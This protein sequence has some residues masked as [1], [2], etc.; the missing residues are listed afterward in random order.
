MSVPDELLKAYYAQI[1]PCDDIASWLSHGD[2]SL[3]YKRELSYN[4]KDNVIRYLSYRDGPTFRASLV[5]K[6]PDK[7]DI[8]PIMSHPPCERSS[9]EPGC[10]VDH[11][12][13]FIM[14]IDLTDYND[15][16][17]CCKGAAIC[18]RCWPLANFAV[19][20]L[21]RALRED[22][23]FTDILW[24]F[25]GRRG[26]H[27]WVC[28]E[29][30][31]KMSNDHRKALVDYLEVIKG[32][33]VHLPPV[34]PPCLQRADEQVDNFFAD[35]VLPVMD[36][37]NN[38]PARE[39]LLSFIPDEELRASLLGAWTAEE[40]VTTSAQKW[41]Q[42][43]AECASPSR[44]RQKWT[45]D[46]A[47]RDIRWYC[48]YPRLDANVSMIMKHLLKSPFCVHPGTGLVSIPLSARHINDFKPWLATAGPVLTSSSTESAGSLMAKLAK[49]QAAAPAVTTEAAQ[50]QAPRRV[51][52]VDLPWFECPPSIWDVCTLTVQ[53]G[54]LPP[55]VAFEQTPLRD[56]IRYFRALI[57]R[58]QH[59]SGFHP[60]PPFDNLGEFD[61]APYLLLHPD[62]QPRETVTVGGPALPIRHPEEE[63]AATVQAATSTWY[64]KED[65][66]EEDEED[67]DGDGR[68]PRRTSD[69]IEE[70]ELA[71]PRPHKVK[72]EQA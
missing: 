19:T 40:E 71:R 61:E 21:D 68:R 5:S 46:R 65:E 57:A 33:K 50:P 39:K 48:C 32:S 69:D 12:R 30:A 27:C 43:C 4:K 29:S 70:L 22:F 44:S 8:G 10:F 54:N 26:V 2:S 24:A 25:S 63:E 53:Q 59:N 56:H 23:G 31:R 66:D 14:D 28:D 51:P 15:I 1:F 13:E 34:L 49:Q 18:E 36:V 3:F 47:I 20:V 64:S 16:R 55:D 62:Q 60:A 58:F 17:G 52:G 72:K 7:I 67:E 38:P 37:L 11:Q 45:L 41:E 42:L 9:V 35:H 6:C